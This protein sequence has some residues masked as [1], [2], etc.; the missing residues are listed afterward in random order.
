MVRAVQAVD[1]A[2]ARMVAREAERE[3]VGLAPGVDA[4]RGVGWRGSVR[5]SM[6]SDLYVVVREVRALGFGARVP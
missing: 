4:A 5:V 3:V 2:A 6:W 1:V